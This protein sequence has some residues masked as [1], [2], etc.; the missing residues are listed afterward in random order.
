MTKKEKIQAI[1]LD[2]RLR[3]PFLKRDLYRFGRFYFP[4]L[5]PSKSPQFHKDWAKAYQG[6][7]NVLN[8]GFRGSAKTT[9]LTVKYAHAIAYRTSRFVTHYCSE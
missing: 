6:K 1:L 8:I 4:H 3:V 2:K 5:F 9:W 7:K